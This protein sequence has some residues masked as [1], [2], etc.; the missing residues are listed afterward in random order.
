MT[1]TSLLGELQAVG[2]RLLL[3][4]DQLTYRSPKGIMT[5]DRLARLSAKKTEIMALLF[6]GVPNDLAQDEAE[7]FDERVAICMFDGGLSEQD[8]LQIAVVQI[9]AR[10]QAIA[11]V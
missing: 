4:G 5:P 3:D 8:A 9:M 6:A 7:E 1:A 10:R 2:A 11:R